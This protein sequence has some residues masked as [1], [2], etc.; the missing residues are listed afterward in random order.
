MSAIGD[1]DDRDP[2]LSGCDES[3]VQ[4]CKPA[5]STSVTRIM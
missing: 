1:R 3:L 2:N 4:S 5:H